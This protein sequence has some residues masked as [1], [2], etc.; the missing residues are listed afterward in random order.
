M[1][2]IK[3]VLTM[4]IWGGTFIAGRI[5]AQEISPFTASFGRPGNTVNKTDNWFELAIS[6]GFRNG[7]CF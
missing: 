3:L 2:L 1:M 7:S 6:R 5:V 4:A